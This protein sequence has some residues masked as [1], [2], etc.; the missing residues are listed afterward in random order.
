MILLLAIAIGLF[1]RWLTGRGLAELADSRLKGEVPLLGMMVLQ[2]AVPNL[3]LAGYAARIAFVAWAITFPAMIWIAWTNR[4][5]P[6]MPLVAVGLLLNMVVIFA[7]AGMPVAPQAVAFVKSGAQVIIPAGDFVHIAANSATRF[8]W[9][10][11]ILPISGPAWL[12]SVASPGDCLLA[13]GIAA[14]LAC[15]DARYRALRP[16][17]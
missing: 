16:N 15:D 14:F 7:N 9:L 13:A 12:R 8:L 11:D 2:L 1:L 5:N 6:G 17:L 3:T 4:R 10:A